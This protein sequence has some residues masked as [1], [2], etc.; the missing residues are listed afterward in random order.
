M[1]VDTSAIL[2]ILF[3]ESDAERYEKAIA[4][5]NCRMSVASLLEAAIVI[6]NR[7]GLKAGGE[8]DALVGKAGIEL[9]PVTAKQAQAGRPAR[10]AALR[11]R[12]SSG[13][14]E[15]RG[16]L[17]IRPCQ[18]ERR[19]AFV[20]GRGFFSNRRRGGVSGDARPASL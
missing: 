18:P 13:G 2:A 4:G 20:Q 3:G 19:A 11:Q 17:R 8:L 6:E 12:Q 7:G 15:F 9:E 1:I 16:L 14:A 5:A 10:V